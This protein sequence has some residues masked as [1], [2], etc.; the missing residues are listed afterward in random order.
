[1]M[2]KLKCRLAIEFGSVPH[3]LIIKMLKTVSTYVM[4]WD[5][6][7]QVVQSKG[8]VVCSVLFSYYHES[9]ANMN[10]VGLVAGMVSLHNHSSF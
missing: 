10:L 3:T 9:L 1:M 6:K 4:L 2:P 8:L 7:T 5:F